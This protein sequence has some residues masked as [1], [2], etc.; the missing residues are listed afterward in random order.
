MKNILVYDYSD[1]ITPAQI[2]HLKK[3]DPELGSVMGLVGLGLT[4][5]K[6]VTGG[7]GR[8]KDRKAQLQIQKSNERIAAMQLQ[9]AANQGQGGVPGW[10]IP[11]V[12]AGGVGLVLVAV[13]ASKKG[14]KK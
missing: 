9:A 11:T 6:Q 8:R 14:G 2:S 7:I 5:L 4:G 3:T 13:L 1:P 12:A 10:V